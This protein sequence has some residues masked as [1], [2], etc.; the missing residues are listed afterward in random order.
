[1]K[2]HIHESN[3]IEK[4]DNKASDDIC[5]VA[6]ELLRKSPRIR[7]HDIWLTQRIV[8]VLQD[9]LADRHRGHYRDIQ[10]QIGGRLGMDPFIIQGATR[11][12]IN[13]MKNYR[14]LD[15]KMMHIRFEKIHPFADGNGR[16]GRMLMWWH[17][18]KLG[19]EPTLILNAKKHEYYK[20]FTEDKL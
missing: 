10:I 19:R 11:N 12:W 9:D 17:E 6:W 7:E 5:L 15:P 4:I 8:T 14:H 20:W 13:D 18:I 2:Q 1:M 3:L 16:T